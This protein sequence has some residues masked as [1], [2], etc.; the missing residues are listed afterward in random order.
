MSD[1]RL[2][3]KDKTEGGPVT[4]DRKNIHSFFD[5]LAHR[6]YDLKQIVSD[7]GYPKPLYREPSFDSLIRLILEQQV[8]LLS[9]KAA[10]LQLRKRIKMVTPQS[11]LDLGEEELRR[12]YFSRQKAGYAIALS[13]SILD[14]DL[15]LPG[16]RHKSDED[17]RADLVRIKG[18]GPWTADS[19]ILLC[20]RRTDIFPVGDIALIN[21]IRKHKKLSS[22]MTVKGILKMSEL[23]KPYRSLATF[24]FWHA[25][26]VER[27]IDI[28]DLAY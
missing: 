28:A 8:S 11:I 21:S 25:Y 22:R 6:D 3:Q 27:N 16:L 26:L 2:L 23:W 5:I 13:K 9:A 17:V 18:I 24:L 15:D 4:Y 20:L 1:R 10:Y 7:Y 14:G 19:Y 12:C